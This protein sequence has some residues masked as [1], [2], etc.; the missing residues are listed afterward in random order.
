MIKLF[1]KKIDSPFKAIIQ[2]QYK[3]SFLKNQYS[4]K[5]SLGKVKIPH[6]KNISR[7]YFWQIF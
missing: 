5:P 2:F 1:L 4:K 6:L 7:N 3:V